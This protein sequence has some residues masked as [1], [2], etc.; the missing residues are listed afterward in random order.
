MV[1]AASDRP[2]VATVLGIMVVVWMIDAAVGDGNDVEHVLVAFNETQFDQS[3]AILRPRYR[4]PFCLYLHGQL[5]DQCRFGSG[6]WQ[7]EM[8][9]DCLQFGFGESCQ[10][11]GFHYL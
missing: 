6:R 7:F 5:F 2:V 11:G 10:D 8:T 4:F 3:T 1:V 9:G